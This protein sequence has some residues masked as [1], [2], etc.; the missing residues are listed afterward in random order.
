[1]KIAILVSTV[2]AFMAV[3]AGFVV[4]T[5]AGKDT[6]IFVGF[7]T[8]AAVFLI[9]QL[10]NLIKAHQTANDV[11]EVKQRTNGPLTEMQHQVNDIAVHLD[12]PPNTHIEEVK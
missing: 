11:A 8:S 3:L 7:A 1:M 2:L 5:L 4:L 10:L 6:S 9:P 12:L